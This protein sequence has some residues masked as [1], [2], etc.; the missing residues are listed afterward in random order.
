MRTRQQELAELESRLEQARRRQDETPDK[1][2]R[3][4]L[5]RQLGGADEARRLINERHDR[6]EANEAARA[7]D[8]Q[9][10]IEAVEQRQEA[11]IRNELRARWQGS[12]ADFERLYPQLRDQWLSD[13]ALGRTAEPV[14]YR[15]NVTI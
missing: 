12:Q 7:A 13:R 5:E 4:R 3:A 8:A 1:A 10:K 9:A 2:E 15:P 11:T 6:I 14:L